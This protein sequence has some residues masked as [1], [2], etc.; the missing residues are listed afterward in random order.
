[1]EN[2]V[3]VTVGAVAGLLSGPLGVLAGGATGAVVGSLVDIAESDDA[4]ALVD[5][6]AR[7]VPSGTA[8]V[9]ALVD[10]P[11]P[12]LLARVAAAVGGTVL[13]HPRHEVEMRLAEAEMEARS[14]DR[15][16]DGQL[17]P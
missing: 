16:P 17:S 15:H 2:L 3:I 11:M 13:R 14:A 9:V 7:S 5:A 6:L 12:T 4:R 1:M 8:A 10:E